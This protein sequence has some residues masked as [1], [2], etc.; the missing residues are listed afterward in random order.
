MML[1]SMVDVDTAARRLSVSSD[2]GA[3]VLFD[4]E[5]AF[6][7]IQHGLS[8]AACRRL[9]FYPQFVNLIRTLGN[10]TPTFSVWEH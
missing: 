3:L 6:P 9:G 1:H 4:F 8:F 5:A 10:T 2:Q 7:S